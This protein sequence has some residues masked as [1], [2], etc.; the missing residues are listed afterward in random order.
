LKSKTVLR[1]QSA[2]SSKQQLSPPGR[3][4][5]EANPERVRA[6]N[7]RHVLA[8]ESLEAIAS[9]DS[10]TVSFS[11]TGRCS[12]TSRAGVAWS[13][14]DLKAEGGFVLAAPHRIL[15]ADGAWGPDAPP[16]SKVAR[17]R[18]EPADDS[19]F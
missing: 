7:E 1:D 8:L 10:W 5:K 9:V 19:L 13:L 12:A 14:A 2:P 6:T 16:R 17:R 15:Y 18:R 4:L 3:H 11:G